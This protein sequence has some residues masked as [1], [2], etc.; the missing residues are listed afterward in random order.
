MIV[1]SLYESITMDNDAKLI[2]TKKG[3]KTTDVRWFDRIAAYFFFSLFSLS[4]GALPAAVLLVT[5]LAITFKFY[6]QSE[7]YRWIDSCC[8]S[9][10]YSHYTLY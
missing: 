4:E 7:L 1:P 6:V 8:K 10:L 9:F 3:N 2:K 5:F